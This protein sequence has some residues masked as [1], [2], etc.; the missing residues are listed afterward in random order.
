M[1]LFRQSCQFC[2]GVHQVGATFGWDFVDSPAI[3]DYEDSAANLY[4]NV[5]YKPRNAG[6][7][8]LVMPALSFLSESAAGDLRQWIQTV[9]STPR[10]PYQ[11][12]PASERPHAGNRTTQPLRGAVAGPQF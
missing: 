7:L 8:G 4:H 1:T 12:P 10:P 6:E 9:G 5:A 3:Y 2:H 11:P